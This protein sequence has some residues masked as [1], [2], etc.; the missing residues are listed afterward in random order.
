MPRRAS[1][2][3]YWNEPF[4]LFPLITVF[5]SYYFWYIFTIYYLI[6]TCAGRTPPVMQGA[7]A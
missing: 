3:N 6:D 7:A 1:G 4:G 5:C 2:T